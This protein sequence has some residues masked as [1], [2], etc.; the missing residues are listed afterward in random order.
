[1]SKLEEGHK[2]IVDL[3]EEGTLRLELDPEDGRLRLRDEASGEWRELPA[4]ASAA[5]VRGGADEGGA[6]QEQAGEADLGIRWHWI[7]VFIVIFLIS[8]GAMHWI[9]S[10]P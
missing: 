3:L 1:M 5:A 7:P 2:R 10:Q 8:A 6:Q 4:V 9:T